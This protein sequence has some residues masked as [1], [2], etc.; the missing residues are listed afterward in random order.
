M[1]CMGERRDEYRISVG[2]PDGKR[3]LGRPRCM[4]NDNIKTYLQKN[5]MGMHGLDCPGLGYGW[6]T[7][8]CKCGYELFG[9]IKCREL[10]D[11]LR[12]C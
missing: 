6:V 11:Y 2:R 4:W 1:V 12:T 10:L 8:D 3:P 9:Y 5:G 7:G